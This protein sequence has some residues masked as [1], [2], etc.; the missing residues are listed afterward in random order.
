[1]D[2]N[3]GSDVATGANEVEDQTQS[4]EVA[5]TLSAA[6]VR[7]NSSSRVDARLELG[8][9]DNCRLFDD[10]KQNRRVSMDGVK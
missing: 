3:D 5:G 2:A 4:H 8:A 7:R 1:M 10:G 6:G 9:G